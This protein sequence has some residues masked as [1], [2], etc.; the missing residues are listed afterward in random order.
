MTYLILAVLCSVAVSIFLKIARKNNIQ[1]AQ[2]IAINYVIATL[3]TWFLLKPNLKSIAEYTAT[4]L[5]FIALGVLLPV[6]FIIM[7]RAVEQAGIVKSDAAQRLSLFIPI[8]WALAFFGEVLTPARGL[9]VALALAAL[10][11]LIYKPNASKGSNSAKQYALPLIGVWVGYGVIDIVF[12]QLAKL[13]KTAF[14][15]NLLVAFVLAGVLMFVYLLL[16]RT[17]WR[18]K[19][20]LAGIVLGVLNFGNILFY[21]RAH[22]V[23]KDNPTLVFA[24]MN[25]GVIALGTLVGAWAFREKISRV[26]AIG[27]VLAMASIFCLFYLAKL[28]PQWA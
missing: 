16:K 27:V 2:A 21:V 5:I 20:M 1:I 24:G 4:A 26:N 13:D 15:G 7:S 28:M 23:F 10:L 19:S 3:M 12:K 9:G 17:N 11:C 18:I 6:V 22:Q 25:M 14:A 8:V